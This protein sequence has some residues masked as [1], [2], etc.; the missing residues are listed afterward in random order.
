M[1]KIFL[2]LSIIG[3]VSLIACNETKTS[4]VSNNDTS[5]GRFV[6]GENPKPNSTKEIT[7]ALPTTTVEFEQTTFDLGDMQQG[8]KKGGTFKFTNTGSEPLIIE[9][10]KGSCG[11]TVPKWPKE[12]IAP[13][14]S[15]EISFEF[16]SKGKKN[17]QTKTITLKGNVDPNPIRLTVK[18]NV[19]VPE[20]ATNDAKTPAT[21]KKK[22]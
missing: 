19:I 21:S 13:G 6:K 5:E 22:G 3:M 16:N 2:T 14:E 12:P 7:P 10:A 15:S 9:S 4:S 8:D 1:K 18:G 20:G 11:C 17:K